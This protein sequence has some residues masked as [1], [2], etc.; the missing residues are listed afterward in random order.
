M[1]RPIVAADLVEVGDLV[2]GAIELRVGADWHVP[3]GSLEWD[4]ERT[5]TMVAYLPSPDEW[6]GQVARAQLN[7]PFEWIYDPAARRWAPHA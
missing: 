7:P 3:A 1:R 6:D 5:R 2:A 4:V